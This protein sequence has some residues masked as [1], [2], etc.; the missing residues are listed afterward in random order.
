MEVGVTEVLLVSASRAQQ[1]VSAL[2]CE[3]A[4]GTLSG[5]RNAGTVIEQRLGQMRI[6][7]SMACSA[8]TTHHLPGLFAASKSVLKLSRRRNMLR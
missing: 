4:E 2:W 1:L 3:Q 5:T 8:L 6:S 7:R